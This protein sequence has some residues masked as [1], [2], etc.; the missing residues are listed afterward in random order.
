MK[1][2]R[3]A[4]FDRQDDLEI[5]RLFF[6]DECGTNLV[7]ETAAYCPWQRDAEYLAAMNY[8]SVCPAKLI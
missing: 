6:I 8:V 7:P 2:A 3:Q 5:E 1:A 4:W